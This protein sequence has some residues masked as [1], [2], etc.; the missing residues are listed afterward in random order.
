VG[1]G[2]LVLALVFSSGCIWDKA[3]YD[4][5]RAELVDADRDG[6]DIYDGDCDDKDAS[7]FPGAV[8]VCDGVDQDCVGGVDDGAVDVVEWYVD[9]DGD[10]LGGG[11]VQTGCEPPGE[12]VAAGGDC[13]DTDP[14]VPGDEVPY[15]GI[16]QDCDGS[17]AADLDGDGYDGGTGLDCDDGDAQ[18]HPGAEETWENG[19][20]DN[21]C[22]GE[23][24]E[25]VL[26]YGY[27]AWTGPSP[28][29]SFGRRTVGAGDLDGDGLA[30]YFVS[31]WSDDS[32][33][34][35]G[36]SVYLLSGI[37]GGSVDGAHALRASEADVGLGIQV[38]VGED[39][40][41]DGVPD[42]AVSGTRWAD[43]AGIVWIASGAGVATGD[44]YLPDEALGEIHGSEADTFVGT[45]VSY[46]GDVDGDGVP[47]LVVGASNATAGGYAGA[48]AVGIW[49]ADTAM[50]AAFDD[51]PILVPGGYENAYFGVVV[52]GA[53]DEDGDGYGD[54]LVSG[55]SRTLARVIAGGPTLASG[56]P[57]VIFT[58]YAG[59][60]GIPG[61]V[62]L[63]GDID[64]DGAREIA[65]TRDD[66]FIF[67]A[68][69]ASVGNS[70][71]YP[72]ATIVNAE[73]SYIGQLADLGDLEGDGRDDLLVSEFWYAP[74]STALVAVHFGD[75]LRYGTTVGAGD[76]A[77]TGRS[78][79][80]SSHFGAS[81]AVVGDA[82]GDGRVDIILGGDEDDEG[83]T[84][85][86]AATAIPLP[87]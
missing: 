35:G 62:S 23:R 41:T 17:D 74:Y 85:A 81:V 9:L 82:D 7:V 80:P 30:D 56:S 5:R 11:E 49:P 22:D 28:Y 27:E 15:D 86:G 1:K 38:D 77:L 67:F 58:L 24:E 10:G 44:V 20:V 39:V 52:D 42:V 36:S 73:G 59:L 55:A 37:G 50:W 40:D 51:A 47:D 31:A 21:D 65:C 83:G 78:I 13:D 53:G 18:V 29:S 19:V 16:D 33:L 57:D 79:R 14:S 3:L 60:D 8:E 66:V 54:L 72:G 69:R 61:D 64:G 76:A 2:G 84:D 25:V 45:G 48:G 6:M 46:A 75:D 68:L 70:L 4:A 43:Q 34:E 32:V 71:D 87:Q 12:A 26:E 63:V